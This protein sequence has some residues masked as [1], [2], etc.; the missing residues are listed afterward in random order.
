MSQLDEALKAYLQDEAQQEDYY[1]L[2][3]ASDF[4]IPLQDEASEVPLEQRTAV[5]PLILQAEGKHYMALFD[6]EERLR[7]W[8]GQPVPFVILA[9]FRA[10]AVTTSQL[11]WAVNLGSGF[12]K[13]LLPEEIDHLKSLPTPVTG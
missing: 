12:A 4:Y 7:D 1:R 3:L 9:G 8:A 11:C 5:R 2:L 10:A 6:S 13:E